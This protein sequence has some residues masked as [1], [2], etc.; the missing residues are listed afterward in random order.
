[1]KV[2]H[3]VSISPRLVNEDETVPAGDKSPSRLQV[4]PSYSYSDGVRTGC[5]LEAKVTQDVHILLNRTLNNGTVRNTF[6]KE[7]RRSSM[8]QSVLI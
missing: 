8:Q 1:M 3:L 2:S 7:L 4:C 5:D 6:K